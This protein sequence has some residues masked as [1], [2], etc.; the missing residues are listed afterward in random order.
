MLLKKVEKLTEQLGLE[1]PGPRQATA[2]L[3]NAE[4]TYLVKND[5]TR[6]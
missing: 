6:S 4:N 3:T 2:G 5:M 1:I